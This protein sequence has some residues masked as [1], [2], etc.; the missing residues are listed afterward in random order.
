MK[1]GVG[2]PNTLVPQLNRQLFLDW[3]RSA[4]Q[5]GFHSLGTLDQPNYD[6]WDQL[7]SLAAAAAVTERIRLA[8]TILQLPNRNEVLVAKQVAVLD[9]LSQG[10]VDLGIAIGGRPAD[11]EVFGARFAGR[12]KRFEAQV[13]R[14]RQVWTEARQATEDT[15]VL[16]PAPVQQPHP[17]LWIGGGTEPAIK[18]AVKLGDG[19]VFGTTGVQRMAQLTP[20]IREWAAAAGRTGYTVNGIAYAGLGQDP[21]AA[22][23]EAA[24]HVL[25]YYRGQTWAPVEQ[26]IH[27]GPPEKIAEDLRHYQDTGI[28]QLI[29]FLEIP[30]LKQLEL[31]AKARDLAKL[32]A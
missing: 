19:Y 20:Q 8:T 23:K 18:R 11:Y 2:L 28:D 14:M 5:A 9:Q 27:H 25:R 32:S 3:A 13:Q 31:F 16:G 26:L 29:V 24:H 22:L 4:E 10:R 12:G 30:D 15:G 6:S 7:V 1:L 21:Q 17:P